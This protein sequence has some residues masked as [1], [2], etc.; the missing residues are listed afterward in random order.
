[1]EENINEEEDN[2][3]ENKK[4]EIF[5]DNS[6]IEEEENQQSRGFGESVCKMDGLK[7]QRDKKLRRVRRKKQ[8]QLK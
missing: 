5:M 4:M 1:M 8:R 2:E 3:R 7:Y 6:F